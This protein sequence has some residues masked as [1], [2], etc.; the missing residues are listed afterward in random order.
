MSTRNNLT[1]LK[2]RVK[3]LLTARAMETEKTTMKTMAKD[4][5]DMKKM[6]K[7]NNDLKMAGIDNG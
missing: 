7:D 2:F 3:A 4:D 1:D 6:A 5:N